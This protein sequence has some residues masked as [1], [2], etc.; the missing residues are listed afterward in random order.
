MR[1]AQLVFV[2]LATHRTGLFATISQ[3]RHIVLD[4]DHEQAFGLPQSRHRVAITI[5]GRQ[6]RSEIDARAVIRSYPVF[7]IVAAVLRMID[8][9][10]QG[11]GEITTRLNYQGEHRVAANTGC[12]DSC[13]RRT[14][15]V[16]I[17]VKHLRNR[18]NQFLA[19]RLQ[20]LRVQQRSCSRRID[21]AEIAR[22]IGTKNHQPGQA[23]SPTSS[24]N[25]QSLTGIVITI[26]RAAQLIFIDLTTYGTALRIMTSQHRYIVL[27]IDHE[28]ATRET[29]RQR[30]AIA[31]GS[32]QH[33]REVDAQSAITQ[34]LSVIA[35][36]LRMIQ[37]SFKGEGVASVG[38]HLQGEYVVAR[39]GAGQQTGRGIDAVLQ[40][41]AT[42]GQAQA[43]H[44]VVSIVAIGQAE[45]TG[46][47]GTEVNQYMQ[48]A[49][50]TT[51]HQGLSQIGVLANR[52]AILVVALVGRSEYP[53][54]RQGILV[55]DAANRRVELLNVALAAVITTREL[56]Y[57]VFDID[58]EA[59]WWETTRQWITVTIYGGQ[60]TG[61]VDTQSRQVFIVIAILSWVIDRAFQLE[62]VAAVRTHGQN[63]YRIAAQPC[64]RSQDIAHHAI[65]QRHTAAA[66]RLGVH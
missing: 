50:T 66:Q 58:G 29:P 47:I 52:V 41:F 49:F 33:T 11:E 16:A 27:D 53:T 43:V 45:I 2:N 9:A 59:A 5:G 22:P 40:R 28:A 46:A 48:G 57:I 17:Q 39:Y 25:N 38:I 12:R 37:R 54:L 13:Q 1:A 34:G 42:G 60:H 51:G 18:I 65:A 21:Q 23:A 24:A 3:Y 63:E 56:R 19:A 62:A 36:S 20:T 7:V 64:S 30:V 6:Q 35:I 8:R 26:V 61:E 4:V 44:P 31:I 32:S 14:H 55:H 15:Q 10:L